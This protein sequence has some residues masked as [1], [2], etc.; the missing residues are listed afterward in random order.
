MPTGQKKAVCA[1]RFTSARR[2]NAL[3]RLGGRSRILL[4]SCS[5]LILRW[6]FPVVRGNFTSPDPDWLGATLENRHRQQIVFFQIPSHPVRE[7]ACIGPA[8][9]RVFEK[10]AKSNFWDAKIAR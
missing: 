6:F 10:T 9:W 7:S 4:P 1:L 5:I 8:I 2:T 3:L